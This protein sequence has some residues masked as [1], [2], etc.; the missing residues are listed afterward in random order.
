[1]RDFLVITI[2]LLCFITATNMFFNHNSSPEPNYDVYRA[3]G[4]KKIVESLFMDDK[5]TPIYRSDA[6]QLC[7]DLYERSNDQ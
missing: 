6:L 4:C 7:H 1:M 5:I 2:G 3:E